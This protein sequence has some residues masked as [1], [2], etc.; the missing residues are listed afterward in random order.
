M[1]LLLAGAALLL[2]CVTARAEECDNS[3]DR[4]L[5][6]DQAAKLAPI[7]AK[8][9]HT[10][11]GEPIQSF[12][13]GRWRILYLETPV[14]DDGLQLYAGDPLTARDVIIWGGVARTNE[15]DE[16]RDWVTSEAPGI[17]DELAACFASYVA[18]DEGPVEQQE[19]KALP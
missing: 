17:P 8:R 16:I 14:P 18:R 12:R 13:S 2:A 10:K 1:R 11:P 6:A 9:T 3:I 19:E 4:S 5:A 7:I 15:E